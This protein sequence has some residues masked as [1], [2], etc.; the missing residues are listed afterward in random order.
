MLPTGLLAGLH[1]RHVLGRSGVLR[2]SLLEDDQARRSL[3]ALEQ[4]LAGAHFGAV[5]L[6]VDL[7]GESHPGAL[8][9]QTGKQALGAHIAHDGRLGVQTDVA[10]SKA[11]LQELARKDK[12]RM[13]LEEAKNKVESYVYQIKNKL[14]DD[15]ENIAK[16]TDEKQREEVKKLAD[17]AEEWMYED[18]YDADLATFE[19]KYA[20]LYTPFSKILFRLAE[21]EARP[22]AIASLNK[23]LGKVEELMTKW[24]AEKPH[25]TEEE[26]KEVLDKVEEVRK[27][28][29]EN[30]EKQAAIKPHEDPVYVSANV[31]LQTKDIEV[32]VTKLSKKKAPKPPKEE[33]KNETKD[34]EEPAADAKDGD[35]DGEKKDEGD[36]DAEPEDKDDAKEG[37]D[38]SSAESEKDKGGDEL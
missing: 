34:E 28:V 24:E 14:I 35:G 2:Q 12:E 8:E 37:D 7:R 16:V 29:S 23:K 27:W 17:D 22:E 32:L 1:L 26:R 21:L 20:E 38:A 19:D 9:I 30:E 6:G 15:E 18:G 13:M 11:K 36:A 33:K 31:P 4:D 3:V 25:I 5:V 10:E